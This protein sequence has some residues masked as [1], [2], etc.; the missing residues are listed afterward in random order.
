[1]IATAVKSVFGT[2]LVGFVLLLRLVLAG[3]VLWRSTLEKELRLCDAARLSLLDF[4]MENRVRR[5]LH[6]VLDYIG[7]SYFSGYEEP[8]LSACHGTLQNLVRTT[9]PGD[10]GTA[11]ADE[12]LR[13]L[14]RLVFW[15]K[16]FLCLIGV[17]VVPYFLGG[18]LDIAEGVEGTWNIDWPF[19]DYENKEQE[20]D[21]HKE[22]EDD[23]DDDKDEE[24]DREKEN[25]DDDNDNKDEEDDKQKVNEEDDEEKDN[26]ERPDQEDDQADQETEKEEE[27]CEQKENEEGED[28]DCEKEEERNFSE[29]IANIPITASIERTSL[30]DTESET[31]KAG[32][33]DVI[34]PQEVETLPQKKRELKFVDGD[35]YEFQ[36]SMKERLIL[37][38]IANEVREFTKF[39]NVRLVLPDGDVQEAASL[40]GAGN[41]VEM[42][43]LHIQEILDEYEREGYDVDMEELSHQE[44]EEDHRQEVQENETPSCFADALRRNPKQ[45]V[46]K[47]PTFVIVQRRTLP[48]IEEEELP[49][50]EIPEDDDEDE[51][52][53]VDCESEFDEEE[54][55]DDDDDD[56]WKFEETRHKVII[57]ISFREAPK[58]EA[59]RGMIRRRVPKALRTKENQLPI[60]EKAVDNTP[61]A[62]EEEKV[63]LE[64]KEEEKPLT[65][66]VQSEQDTTN[67]DAEESFLPQEAGEENYSP[68]EEGKEKA[69]PQEEERNVFFL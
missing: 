7:F 68:Q 39:Y 57:G 31:S 23:D 9:L 65:Q 36:L 30:D 34:P 3:G 10:Q 61:Q 1:M 55:E 46:V 14:N 52:M 4:R 24:N 21:Q 32:S 26:Q 59:K 44:A 18:T 48:L 6:T 54:D 38:G 41:R 47:Q 12:V 16:M 56:D 58:E 60:E 51:I 37:R 45:P 15:P 33:V 53:E 11:A 40:E 43:F 62:K 28:E 22:N 42:A 5:A 69:C 64:D 63:L 8:S 66:E 25:E 19:D 35:L 20:D 2:F 13:D 67:G 49:V 29:V 50:E 27:E 17:F